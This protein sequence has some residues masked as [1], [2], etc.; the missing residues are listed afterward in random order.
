[1]NGKETVSIIISAYREEDKVL[2]L[3]N[4]LSPA[5]D[6]QLVAVLA[7]GDD[8][9][10]EPQKNKAVTIRAQRG[11]ARQMNAGAKVATGGILLFLHADTVIDPVSFDNVRSALNKSNVAGGA[12]RIKIDAPSKGYEFLSAIVNFRSKW[13]KAPYGDQALFIKRSIYDKIGGF[14]DVPI[15]EDVRFVK[16]MKRLGSLELLDDV[17]ITSARKWESEGPV[18]MTLR[19]WSILLVHKAGI[20]P[21]ILVKW[22]YP[23]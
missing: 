13:F 21:E 14:D 22:Y 6:V 12:Y 15:M 9:T 17:A 11:R 19:N 8:E 20:N 18:Y 16:A 23:E 1:M 5:A 10:L 7:E 4:M 2:K 3:V